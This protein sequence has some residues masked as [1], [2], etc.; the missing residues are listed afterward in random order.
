MSATQRVQRN[1]AAYNNPV[2]PTKSFAKVVSESNAQTETKHIKSQT[3]AADI[4]NLLK[5]SQNLQ[6]QIADWNQQKKIKTARQ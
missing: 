4:W 6:S 2:T 1:I 5:D 3:R